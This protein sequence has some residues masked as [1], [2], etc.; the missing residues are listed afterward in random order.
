[1]HEYHLID[2]LPI[3]SIIS[4]NDL[5]IDI[6]VQ[7]T[8]EIQHIPINSIFTI[9]RGYVKLIL[10]STEIESR[11]KLLQICTPHEIN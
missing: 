3:I 11:D 10:N 8:D 5:T 9:Y 2:N 6:I 7:N 4:K 1:M